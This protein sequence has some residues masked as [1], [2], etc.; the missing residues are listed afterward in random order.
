[1]CICIYLAP[2]NLCC[3][4]KRDIRNLLSQHFFCTEHF[5]LNFRFCA[6]NNPIA[7]LFCSFFGFFNKL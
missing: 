3:S 7:F 4:C 2:Q 5:M 1:M 6:R